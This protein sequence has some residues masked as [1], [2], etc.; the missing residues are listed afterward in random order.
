MLQGI[1]WQECPVFEGF[2]RILPKEGADVLAT[3]GEGEDENPLIVTWQFGKGRSMAFATDCS[4]HWAEYFQPWRFYGQFWRQ[5]VRW[6]A[7]EI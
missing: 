6:L 7:G 2:N 3:I 5:A 1:P 4:P